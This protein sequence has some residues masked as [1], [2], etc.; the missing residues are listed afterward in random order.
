M[1]G[2]LVGSWSA[3]CWTREVVERGSGTGVLSEGTSLQVGNP[4]SM[5][6]YAG[7]AQVCSIDGCD[8]EILLDC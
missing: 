3:E 8:S 4:A 2:G 1:V 5:P 7:V 6:L